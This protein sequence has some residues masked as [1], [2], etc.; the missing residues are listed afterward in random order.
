MAGF[1]AIEVLEVLDLLYSKH[2]ECNEKLLENTSSHSF[3]QR[4]RYPLRVPNHSK[5][6]FC[7]SGYTD[8]N[9]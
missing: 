2:K 1:N 7:Q 4:G 9:N 6:I 3:L 5:L 8:K